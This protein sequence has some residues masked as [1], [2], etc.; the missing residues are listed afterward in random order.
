MSD[1]SDNQRLIAAGKVQRWEVLK[2]VTTVNIALATASAVISREGTVLV[3]QFFLATVVMAVVGLL[4]LW[5]YN[6]RITGARGYGGRLYDWQEL[7]IFSFVI[8]LSMVPAFLIT[9]K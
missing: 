9:W 6:N 8:L 1:Q 3:W 7:S 2:W 4:L 5:H